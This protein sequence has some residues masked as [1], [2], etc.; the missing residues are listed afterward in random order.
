MEKQ[1]KIIIVC[2]MLL[3]MTGC[4]TI[5]TSDWYPYQITFMDKFMGEMK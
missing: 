2:V 5:G 1:V 3:F 4:H